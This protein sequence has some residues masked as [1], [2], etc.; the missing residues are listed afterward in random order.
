[1]FVFFCHVTQ[2]T[3]QPFF[4]V[5]LFLSHLLASRSCNDTDP[6]VRKTATMCVAKLYDINPELVEDQA[7]LFRVSFWGLSK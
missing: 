5:T 7:L 1:M 3:N 6:Y 2:A 4:W